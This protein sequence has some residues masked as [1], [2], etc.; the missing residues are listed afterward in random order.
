ML[1]IVLSNSSYTQNFVAARIFDC[2]VNYGYPECKDVEKV[3]T[4]SP[5]LFYPSL[6]LLFFYLSLFH[7][8]ALSSPMHG[9]SQEFLDRLAELD[10]AVFDEYIK[11]KL[12]PLLMLIEPGMNGGYFDWETHVLPNGI[13][14]YVMEIL[15]SLVYVHA[16]VGITSLSVTVCHCDG[17]CACLCL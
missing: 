15:L 16:E 13:R 8:W 4:L 14:S 12:E 9:W 11:L 3:A 5:L 7:C 10:C 2:F 1:L 17:V 6:S